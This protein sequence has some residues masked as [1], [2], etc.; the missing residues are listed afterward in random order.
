MS[1]GSP[2][3]PGERGHQ[4]DRA[5]L[6][7][8]EDRI[9]GLHRVRRTTDV[10]VDA[11]LPVVGG[12][13]LDEP[14]DADARRWRPRRR[15]DRASA[16]ISD[17]R[18]AGRVEIGDVEIDVGTP[19]GQI[20]AHHLGAGARE[21]VGERRAD[22]ARGAR[23]HHDRAVQLQPHDPSMP[24]RSG[25][26]PLLHLRRR[27]P[28]RITDDAAGRRARLAAD[29]GGDRGRGGIPA[30]GALVRPHVRRAGPPRS[31]RS[32]RGPQHRRLL[33]AGHHRRPPDEP[34]R[35][36]RHAR[37]PGVD[38][39]PGRHGG[40][41]DTP[42]WSALAVPLALGPIVLAGA[43][44]VPSAVRLG[45]TT[46]AGPAELAL[47]RRILADHLLCFAGIAVVLVVQIVL[48]ATA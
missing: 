6:L 18:A 11:A 17:E 40:T 30:R 28:I 44:T 7:L 19:T 1:N 43:R 24:R 36:A 4:D 38:R 45:Q 39:R 10:H 41:G 29:G 33:P 20:G 48:A 42:W 2:S 8:D 22:A 16:R 3:E 14:A 25:V 46:D 5:A 9:R 26:G 31:G 32:G 21:P 35:R 12:E 34:A 37:D 27:T 47:A 23:D 15:A 13:L